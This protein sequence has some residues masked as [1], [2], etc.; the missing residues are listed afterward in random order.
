MGKNAQKVTKGSGNVFAD[1]GFSDAK[2]HYLKAQIVTEICRLMKGRKLTQANAGKL[3]NIT[4]SEVSRMVRGHFREYSV[5]RLMEFLTAFDRD[6]EI[7]S[8]KRSKGKHGTITF[9]PSV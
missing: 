7:V 9:Q 3:M 4:Q 1:L 5:Y 2:D 8:R 6:V